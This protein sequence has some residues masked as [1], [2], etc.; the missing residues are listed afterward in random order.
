MGNKGADL[1]GQPRRRLINGGVRFLYIVY[2]GR[3]VIQVRDCLRCKS[4][5]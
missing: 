5:E 4:L 3:D 1:L 2:N